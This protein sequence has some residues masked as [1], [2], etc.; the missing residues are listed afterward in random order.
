MDLYNDPDNKYYGKDVLKPE[1][2]VK[3][4]EKTKRRKYEINLIKNSTLSAERN[5]ISSA[6]NNPYKSLYKNI[7]FIYIDC[8]SVNIF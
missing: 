7:L 4:D 1:V 2:E 3:Y 6:E 5:K 8:I